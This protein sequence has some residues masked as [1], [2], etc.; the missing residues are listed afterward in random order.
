M[1]NFEKLQTIFR[2]VFDDESLNIKREYSAA[3]IEDWDSLAQINLIVAIEKEFNL[4]FNINEIS[5]LENIGDM[6][7]LIERKLNE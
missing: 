7:D 4:K 1:D 5:A 6:L 3:D 2:E